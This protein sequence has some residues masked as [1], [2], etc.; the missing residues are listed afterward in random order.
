MLDCRVLEQN[1]Q[2][3][4]TFEIGPQR[5]PAYAAA[6]LAHLTA[7]YCF[8]VQQR[9]EWTATVLF[10][11]AS[12]TPTPPFNPGQLTELTGSKPFFHDARFVP[13]RSL[14]ALLGDCQQVSG[15]RLEH[16]SFKGWLLIGWQQGVEHAIPDVE[17]ALY[18]FGDKVLIN[19]LSLQR[20][21]LEQQYRFLFSVVPLAVVLINESDDVSWVNQAAIELLDLEP[22]EL[23]PSSAD[24]SAGMLA[25]R[26]RALNQDA[27]QQTATKLL[28]NAD[29][30][31]REWLWAFPERVLSVLTQPIH[32]PYFKGR[33]WLFNDVTELYTKTEQ[34][35]D[36]NHEIENLISVIAHDL[37]SPLATLNFIFDFLPV[38][39]PLNEEQTE[40]IDY[41]QK[42]IQRGLNLID[43]IVYFNQLTSPKQP[44][45]VA[46][47][48]VDSLLELVVDG[49]SAHAHQ[50]G[51]TIHV[52]K[53]DQPVLIQAEPELLVRVMENL[54]SNALKFSSFGRNVYLQ[55][56]WR[57]PELTIA[58][59]DEGPGISLEDRV[60]LFK[61]FQRLSAQPTNNEGSSGL[62]LSIVKALT[63]KLG[64]T[65]EVE[66]TVN[67]GTTFRLVF[68]AQY[69][70]VG[71][72]AC[73]Q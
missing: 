40:T 35:A 16:Y 53:T 42:T 29:F 60:R 27:I 1:F 48:A 22:D 25:F 66:S 50:K 68:P 2:R 6:V 51:I 31:A 41:G 24:V 7:D 15:F 73:A 59:R 20:I 11:S 67:V 70:R 26:N 43:S 37:K 62:G 45:A 8:I 32:S 34:L 44:V 54:M 3:I 63:E 23:R 49:F 12:V 4:T 19:Y 21:T 58:V 71:S 46:D 38:Y 52:Q 64:A 9:D 56:E 72:A 14:K 39:G 5:L 69:V 36:A 65:I 17:D 57:G 10:S 18:R 33:I 47:V 30:T 61:R 28:H 13:R 55:T